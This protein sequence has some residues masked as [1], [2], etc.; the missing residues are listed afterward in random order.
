MGRIIATS[1][2]L[3][4]YDTHRRDLPWRHTTDPWAILVSEVMS[5]QT[6]VARVAPLWVAWMTRWPTAAAVAAAPT[7]EVLRAWGNLGYPRRALRL[8]E[9]AAA[10]IDAV[11]TTY[12]GLR[13]LPGVGDY[14]ARAVLVFAFGQ[15]IP[16]VDVNV[17]RV[18]SRLVTAH[19]LTPS[20]RAGDV[21]RI[22]EWG[23][24]AATPAMME[25][26]AL[27]C[28]ATNPTCHSCPLLPQCAWV[29]AGSPQ[30]TAEQLAKRTVQ[31][32]TGTNRQVRGRIMALLRHCDGPVESATVRTVWSDGQMLTN[33]LDELLADGLVERLPDGRFH[34]PQ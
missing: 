8:K 28:T 16:V 26:G 5:H 18:F 10:C 3:R 33:A 11:P 9:A 12:A 13:A 14:T 29:R 31:K 15:A 20:A 4:W 21:A 30:P 34:L 2:L 27:V 6:P 22:E 1:P 17:R 23:L 19:F 32:F 7:A 24:A 25:L